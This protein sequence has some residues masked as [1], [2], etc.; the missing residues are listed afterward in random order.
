MGVIVRAA[1]CEDAPELCRLICLLAEYEKMADRCTASPESVRKMMTEENG[2]RGIIA[3]KD[4]KAVGMAVYS[5]YKLATFS[6]K[7]VLYIEDIF[8]EEAER[9]CGAGKMLF[10]KLKETAAELECIKLEWKCLAWN[11]SARDFYEKQGGES[12]DGWLTYTIDLRKE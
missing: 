5:L 4:G 2:L 10:N 7:R 6:G 8:V 12:D 9:G 3:E 1:S 11:R